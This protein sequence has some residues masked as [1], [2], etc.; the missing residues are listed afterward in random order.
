MFR[1]KIVNK[2]MTLK[3]AQVENICWDLVLRAVKHDGIADLM[4]KPFF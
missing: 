2:K 1:G 4:T 3:L